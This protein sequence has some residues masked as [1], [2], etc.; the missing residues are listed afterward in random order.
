MTPETAALVA[1]LASTVSIGSV[2]VA[3]GKLQQRVESGEKAID[4]LDR[5][6]ASRESVQA[7]ERAA[8]AD[9]Q[10]LRTYLDERF[11]HLEEVVRD[12]VGK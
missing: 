9:V 1:V 2:L 4:R 6:K 10:S 3:A 11:R 8:A 7:V 12:E 5:D